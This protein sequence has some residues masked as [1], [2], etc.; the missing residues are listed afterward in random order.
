MSL[1]QPRPDK[2]R[3][4]AAPNLAKTTPRTRTPKHCERRR[5]RTPIPANPQISADAFT[6]ILLS[7]HNPR[8]N[9]DQNPPQTQRNKPRH[10]PRWIPP[11]TPPPQTQRN[12]PPQIRP[13]ERRRSKTARVREYEKKKVKANS[14]QILARERERVIWARWWGDLLGEKWWGEKV[15]DWNKSC[16]LVLV[17]CNTHFPNRD[18]ETKKF[19]SSLPLKIASKNFGA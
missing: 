1:R 5:R 14:G 9:P 13:R 19:E 18:K 3:L 7:R 4:N 12:E 6:T 16:I 11:Q 8:P 2:P 15:S 10:K 17:S